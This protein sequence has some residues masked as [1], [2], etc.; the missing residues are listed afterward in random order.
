MSKYKL[1]QQVYVMFYN[2]DK[3]GWVPA[4]GF[5]VTKVIG[6]L[7]D[8]GANKQYGV[9]V[10]PSITASYAEHEIFESK[11]ELFKHLETNFIDR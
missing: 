9:E 4:Q 11:E 2:G 6:S 5:I 8:V 7:L 3:I 1:N 10:A